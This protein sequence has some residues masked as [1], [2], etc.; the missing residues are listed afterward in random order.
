MVKTHWKFTF[1]LVIILTVLASTFMVQ[2]PT[3]KPLIGST[4]VHAKEQKENNVKYTQ[5][6]IFIDGKQVQLTQKLMVI[7][8]TTLVPLRSIFDLMDIS[9]SWDQKSNQITVKKEGKTVLLEPNSNKAKINNQTVELAY[10]PLNQSGTTYI[11]LRFIAESFGYLVGYDK[12]THTISISTKTSERMKVTYIVDGDT[13]DVVPVGKENT[14]ANR[15]RV[16]MIGV[17]T[18]E[19]TKEAGIEPGGKEAAA[20]TQATLLNQEVYITLDT[21]NDPYGRTLAY[22]HLLNGEFYNATLISLGYGKTM[23][24]APNTL[25]ADYFNAL[26]QSA[27]EKKLNLWNEQTYEN[28]SADVKSQLINTIS[29]VGL[30]AHAVNLSSTLATSE[31][32]SYLLYFLYPEARILMSGHKVYEIATDDNTRAIITQLYELSQSNEGTVITHKQLRLLFLKVLGIHEGAFLVQTLDN[33]GLLPSGDGAITKAE[34]VQILGKLASFI[35]TINELRSKYDLL[36]IGLVQLNEWSDTIKDNSSIED[37]LGTIKKKVHLSSIT[38]G[39]AQ[40][41]NWLKDTI[42]SWFRTEPSKNEIEEVINKT[43]DVAAEIQ[44]HIEKKGYWLLD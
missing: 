1:T 20:F 33:L 36:E 18:P 9:V 32:A 24:I 13:V 12:T 3:K 23:N 16:R 40:A 39:I 5:T 25:W 7:Q 30:D 28:L 19:S 43:E 27:K 10:Q 11:P 17:N 21:S 37:F 44:E 42:G 41:T 29:E 8:G 22:I 34:T 31:A 35:P 6:D 38:D 4:T 15:I 14:K 2:F 26:E